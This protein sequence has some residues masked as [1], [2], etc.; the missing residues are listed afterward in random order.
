M[1][2]KYDIVN[3]LSS[4][5]FHD[6]A[7]NSLATAASMSRGR[8]VMQNAAGEAVQSNASPILLPR[9]VYRPIWSGQEKPDSVETQLVT[10]VYG[11]HEAITDEY[12]PDPT[13]AGRPAWA[14]NLPIVCVS[15]LLTTYLAGTDNEEAILGHVVTPPAGGEMRVHINA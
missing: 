14:V 5:K 13:L 1:A 7:I 4:L 6:W 3:G 10:T 12:V 8:W 11:S 15:G 9:S 2:N